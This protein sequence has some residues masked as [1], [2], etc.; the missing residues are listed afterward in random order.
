MPIQASPRLTCFIS[1]PVGVGLSAP[2][3]SELWA[4]DLAEAGIDFARFLDTFVED[5]FPE[6]EDR[7]IHI[8][9]ESFGGHYGPVYTAMMRRKLASLILVDPFIDWNRLVLGAYTHLCVPAPLV[10]NGREF[11][12]TACKEME[13]AYPAC[14]AGGKACMLTYDADTCFAGFLACQSIWEQ[15]EQVVVPGGWD[16]YDDRR[17]C[18]DP[19]ICGGQGKL[20]GGLE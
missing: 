3:D 2:N 13:K 12:A 20:P 14:E 19:P 11:N 8:T 9:A 17:I 7:P 10:R 16:P 1:Q 5:V 15:F 18:T 4:S 6:L